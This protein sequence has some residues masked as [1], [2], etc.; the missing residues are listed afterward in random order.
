MYDPVVKKKKKKENENNLHVP[1]PQIYI[2]IKIIREGI[3]E[4]ARFFIVH[5]NLK[6]K[7]FL[8]RLGQV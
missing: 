8:T 5:F 6:H 4:R 2:L 1:Q 3:S 7:W